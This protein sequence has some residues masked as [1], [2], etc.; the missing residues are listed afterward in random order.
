MSAA[1]AGFVPKRPTIPA[2]Q[3][4]THPPRVAFPADACD[5][6]VHVIGPQHL[7]PHGPNPGYIPNEAPVSELRKMLGAL[8][9]RR[10]VIVQPSY[11]GHDNSCTLDALREGNGDFRGVVA[12]DAGTVTDE[13][14]HDMHEAGVRG[15]RLNVTAKEGKADLTAIRK[16]AARIAGMQ[17]WHLQLYFYADRMPELDKGLADLPVPVVIDHFGYVNASDG[18]DGTGFRM[19]RRL[20]ESGRAWFKLSAPYRQSKLPP[21]FEDVGPLARC[22][23]GI[24]PDQCVWGTD[25]P[26]VSRNDTGIIRVPNDGELADALIGWIP[27]AQDRQRILVDNPARLYDFRT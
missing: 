2:H 8:G 13:V 11:Y 14:L 6:H 27:D 1:P 3:P 20:A 10:S 18:I 21:L 19:L 24:V 22:L 16:T 7:Y 23:F 15:V 5:A 9:C 17:G 26:H 12:F 4:D 25:W